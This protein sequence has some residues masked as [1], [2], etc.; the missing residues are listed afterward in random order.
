MCRQQ[1]VPVSQVGEGIQCLTG[2]EHRPRSSAENR[3]GPAQL[4][5]LA[6][7][8]QYEKSLN[9]SL[10]SPGETCDCRAVN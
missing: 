1:S 3:E 10:R 5:L 2:L 9:E 4:C 7:A 8:R 6:S